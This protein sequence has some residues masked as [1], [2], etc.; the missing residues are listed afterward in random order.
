GIWAPKAHQAV[1]HPMIRSGLTRLGLMEPGYAALAP[2]ERAKWIEK[3]LQWSENLSIAQGGDL[4]L[5]SPDPAAQSPSPKR[6]WEGTGGQAGRPAPAP[7]KSP[8]AKPRAAPAASLA[9][10]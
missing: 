5:P 7:V 2:H 3:V 8:A 1:A 9:P 6:G 4:T 10:G